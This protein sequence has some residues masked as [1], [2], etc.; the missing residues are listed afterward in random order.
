MKRIMLYIMVCVMLPIKAF[1]LEPVVLAC[2][3]FPPF[4]YEENGQI[5][6]I[7][8]EIVQKAFDDAGI[9]LE[10][11][12]YPFARAFQEA[13]N[14]D[15][16][17]I[18]NLFKSKK[19]EE[20]F[21]Y[22]VPVIENKLLFFKRKNFRIKFENVS[23]LEGLNI[24]VMKDYRYSPEFDEAGDLFTKDVARLHK[25]HFRKLDLGRIDLYPCDELVGRYIA[26]EERLM[27][28]FNVLPRPLSVNKGYIGFTKG[29]HQE[30]I[31]K[32]NNALVEMKKTGKVA[33]IINKYVQL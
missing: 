21:D 23:D 24:G 13:K 14:G 4:E 26:T 7:L 33:K 9:L 25:L 1:A 31:E 15:V 12:M 19:R 18:F 32:I 16:A 28:K 6:G 30:L 11:R 27:D 5:K 3:D 2:V 20:W 10:L 29:K 17:G 22:S 8:I